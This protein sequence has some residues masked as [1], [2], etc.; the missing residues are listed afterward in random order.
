MS[1]IVDNLHGNQVNQKLD[2]AVTKRIGGLFQL[3]LELLVIPKGRGVKDK[4]C[5]TANLRIR[6]TDT[7]RQALLLGMR[8]R[9]SR[10]LP[11]EERRTEASCQGLRRN[12]QNRGS[13]GGVCQVSINRLT[14][15]PEEDVS[16]ATDTAS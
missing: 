12:S 8:T 2:S 13:K 1:N 11:T 6:S 3:N 14:R 9:D 7:D 10:T 16:A 4:V 5:A 15:D